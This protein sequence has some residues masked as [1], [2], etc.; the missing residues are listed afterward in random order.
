M[1]RTP[2]LIAATLVLS[3][4]SNGRMNLPFIPDRSAGPVGPLAAPS[5][6]T[7]TYLRAAGEGDLFEITSSQLALQRTQNPEVRAFAT[8]MIDHH[9][10]GTNT[11]L[12][13]AG[14]AGVAPPPVV[15][16]PGKQALIEELGGAVGFE[17]DRV[18]V[19][20]QLAA[21]NEAL[22]LLAG[23]AA[24]GDTPSVRTAAGKLAPVVQR[25]LSE[26]AGLQ[27][28]TGAPAR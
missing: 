6:A 13:A 27:S 24:A 4:C 9:T 17:F 10:T 7:E 11:L 5:P 26:L 19:Q 15:L 8:M 3:A 20:Q 25:H 1:K 28:R 16:G 14:R 18:Y 23:Y 22:A 2:I 21:H 12:T